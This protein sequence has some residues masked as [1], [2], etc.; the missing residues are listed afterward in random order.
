MVNDKHAFKT[1]VSMN[2]SVL[3]L[4]TNIS[5]Q[6]RMGYKQGSLR[7]CEWVSTFMFNERKYGYSSGIQGRVAGN[8]RWS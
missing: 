1:T 6:G 4:W 3:F 5:M 2:R 7:E 8:Q